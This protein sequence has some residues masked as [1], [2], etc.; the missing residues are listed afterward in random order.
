MMSSDER[1]RDEYGQ[2]PEK[3]WQSAAPPGARTSLRYRPFLDFRLRLDRGGVRRTRQKLR[4]V[5]SEWKLDL[6]ARVVTF[7]VVKLSD[8]FAHLAGADTHH[9]VDAGVV[10]GFPAE[11]FHAKC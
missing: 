3:Y 5:R 4:H 2:Q 9:R 1:A 7:L 10:V 8:S 11:H 6:N